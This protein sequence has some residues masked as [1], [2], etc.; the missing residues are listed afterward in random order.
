LEV[1]GLNPTRL[2]TEGWVLGGAEVPVRVWRGV[3]AWRERPR[4]DG[5]EGRGGEGRGVGECEGE[6]PERIWSWAVL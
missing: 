3:K 5:R 4:E 2:E 1:I 6:G